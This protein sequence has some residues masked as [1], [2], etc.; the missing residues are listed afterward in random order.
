MTT[1]GA[2]NL[3]ASLQKRLASIAEHVAQSR[4]EAQRSLDR[5]HRLRQDLNKITEEL[6]PQAVTSHDTVALVA[7][8]SQPN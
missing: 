7:P 6:R 2:L 4:D 5:V 3:L 1:E 8:A